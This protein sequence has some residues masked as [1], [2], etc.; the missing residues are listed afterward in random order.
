MIEGVQIYSLCC[1]HFSGGHSIQQQCADYVRDNGQMMEGQ[2]F[3]SD[4][5]NLNCKKVIHAVGPKWINGRHQEER[6]LLT[7]IDNCFDEAETHN[8]QSI[9]IPPISTGIFEFPLDRAVKT[10]VD[11]VHERAK[12]GEFLPRYVTFVDN[13]EASLKLFIEE[14]SQRNWEAS[15]PKPFSQTV[16]KFR[17]SKYMKFMSPSGHLQSFDIVLCKFQICQLLISSQ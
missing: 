12:G 10:I 15:K 4:A 14:L 6:T 8:L 2:V 3:T 16:G 5:G 13:Q 11:A 17:R 1:C 9:A 7:C